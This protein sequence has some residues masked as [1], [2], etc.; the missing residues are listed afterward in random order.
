MIVDSAVDF[1][2]R[3]GRADAGRLD[4]HGDDRHAVTALFD[5]GERQVVPAIQRSRARRLHGPVSCRLSHLPVTGVCAVFL[6]L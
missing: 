6:T 1:A 4:E 3:I 5:G 2:S